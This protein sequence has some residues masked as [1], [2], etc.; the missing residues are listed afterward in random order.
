[1][2]IEY[3]CRR[4]E[5]R[6]RIEVSDDESRGSLDPARAEVCPSC[7]QRVGTGPVRCR[8][9]GMTFDVAFPHWHRRCDLARGICPACR[10]Q[11]VSLCVC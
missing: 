4:C 2:S 10:G 9:C 6:F 7:S 8:I 3:D 1:M 11:Y 5:T